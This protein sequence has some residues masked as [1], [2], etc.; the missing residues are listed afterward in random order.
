MKADRPLLIEIKGMP[1]LFCL[2][3]LVLLTFPS[4]LSAEDGEKIFKANCASCHSTGEN[5]MVGPG[6]KGINEKRKPEWLMSWI[7]NSGEMIKS[8]DPD[9]KAIYEEFGKI[10]MPASVLNDDEIRSVLA[11]L[12]DPSAGQ[13][14][15]SAPV[16]VNQP[17]EEPGLSPLQVSFLLTGIMFVIL[18]LLVYLWLMNLHQSLR[19]KGL[20]GIPVMNEPLAERFLNWT[21]RHK[22]LVTGIFILVFLAGVAGLWNSVSPFL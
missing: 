14:V 22:S 20:I 13:P 19:A 12:K 3:I 6:L 15:S 10:M 11:F 1:P 8:G 5:R 17:V 16:E 7:K 18:Y 21:E 9:A 2:F 4:F